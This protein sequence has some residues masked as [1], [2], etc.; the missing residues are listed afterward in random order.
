MIDL[1]NMTITDT[2]L[3]SASKTIY[4]PIELTVAIDKTDPGQEILFDAV[5]KEIKYTI[6]NG[7]NQRLVTV[8]S[9]QE[10]GE[11]AT[12]ILDHVDGP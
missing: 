11:F 4:P 3:R 12:F 6:S 7:T 9:V 5:G 2:A 1:E 10:D 8:R